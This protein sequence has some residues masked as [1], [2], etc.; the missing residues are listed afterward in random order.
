MRV[1]LMRH[2]ESINNMYARIDRKIYLEERKAEPELSE[3]GANSSN[4]MG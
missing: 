2:G 3:T 1:I 4:T